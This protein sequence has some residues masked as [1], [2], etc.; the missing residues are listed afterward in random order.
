MIVRTY[1]IRATQRGRKQPGCKTG[2]SGTRTVPRRNRFLP[3]FGLNF[4][5]LFGNGPALWLNMQQAYD[6]WR[7]QDKLAEIIDEIETVEAA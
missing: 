1:H 4:G 6:L 3:V 7:A 5:K 2:T